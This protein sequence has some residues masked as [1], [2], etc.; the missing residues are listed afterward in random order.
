MKDDCEFCRDEFSHTTVKEY[1]NWKVQ[2]FLNQ[3]YL[4]RCLIKL[5]KHKVDLTELSQ[6]ERNELFEKVLPEV[7]GAID[8]LFEPDLYNQATL[9]NDCRHFHLHVIPRYEDK[10]EFNGEV[11]RDQ[12]WNSNY[13]PY[14]R[15]FEIKDESF[16]KLQ[17]KISE[18]LQ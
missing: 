12:N 7:Q 8:S 16:K 3:Y 11:F 15:D 2:L 14:P 17:D 4:G 10:R 6:D 1:E 9:G 5:K 18:K 13:T